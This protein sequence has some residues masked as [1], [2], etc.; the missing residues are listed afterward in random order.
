M[1][2][3]GKCGPGLQTLL[4]V[5]FSAHPPPAATQVKT[6]L[7]LDPLAGTHVVASGQHEVTPQEMPFGQ[8]Q[9]PIPLIE[10]SLGAQLC[11]AGQRV[12]FQEE[13]A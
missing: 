10:N 3:G 2:D 9:H 12:S 8:G 6:S 13:Y 5:M 11:V 7:K 4:E 1:V